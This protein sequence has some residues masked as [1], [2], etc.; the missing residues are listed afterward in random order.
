MDDIIHYPVDFI[1]YQT[2]KSGGS[3][4]TEFSGVRRDDRGAVGPGPAI[5]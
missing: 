2:D 4:L 3:S 5:G 1:N